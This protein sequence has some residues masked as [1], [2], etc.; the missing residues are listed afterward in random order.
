MIELIISKGVWN[1]MEGFTMS[2]IISQII[3]AFLLVL[4]YDWMTDI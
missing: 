3:L 1:E 4:T 2:Y